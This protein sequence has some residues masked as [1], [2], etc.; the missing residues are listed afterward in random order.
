MISKWLRRR[1]LRKPEA[2]WIY[3][4]MV[5]AL[6]SNSALQA[7]QTTISTLS[8]DAPYPVPAGRIPPPPPP[9]P[10]F[11]L[12]ASSNV[13]KLGEPVV[14]SATIRADPATW[15]LYNWIV[16]T[17]APGTVTVRYVKHN[18]IPLK[19]KDGITDYPEGP[20]LLQR[21]F[22]ESLPSGSGADIPLMLDM[23]LN[24]ATVL[25]DSSIREEYSEFRRDPI[26]REQ[27]V[28]SVPA[29]ETKTYSF[30]QP[31]FYAVKLRYQYTGPLT[32]PEIFPASLDSNE[33]VFSIQ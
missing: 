20:I 30:D 18:G 3:R 1:P 21:M 23:S 19:P 31:G 13:Y 2:G 29:F 17:F 10:I 6:V 11:I 15:P 28:I 24:G 16:C 22:L 27:I 4:G 9:P 32:R 25:H 26:T 7:A 12:Q 14:L 5:A 8:G 33:I